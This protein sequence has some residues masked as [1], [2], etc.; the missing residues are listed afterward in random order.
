MATKGLRGSQVWMRESRAGPTVPLPSLSVPCDSE[1]ATEFPLAPFPQLGNKQVSLR[2]CPREAS[3][4]KVSL[5][6]WQ[7][8]QKGLSSGWPTNLCYGKLETGKWRAECSFSVA[9]RERHLGFFSLTP[10]PCPAQFSDKSQEIKTSAHMSTE[11]WSSL[12]SSNIRKINQLT[13]WSSHV[14]TLFPVPQIA[15]QTNS[16]ISFVW[17]VGGFGGKGCDIDYEGISLSLVRSCFGGSAAP[18][19]RAGVGEGC[20]P[21]SA[22]WIGLGPTHSS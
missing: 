18:W 15:L 7:L 3:T 6:W 20:V 9:P 14:E 21:C 4:V 1:Q 16:P 11:S 17:L 22:V 19:W 5:S 2:I 10:H 8:K 13:A 12:L